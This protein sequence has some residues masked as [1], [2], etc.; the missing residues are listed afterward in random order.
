MFNDE[1]E[2]V[3]VNQY[4]ELQMYFGYDYYVT[5]K[6]KISQPTLGDIID[7]GD[8]KFYTMVSTLCANP[9]SFR[10]Q[11]WKKGIDWN[12]LSDWDLFLQIYKS[13]TPQDTSLILGE[14][15]LSWFEPHIKKEEQNVINEDKE[16]KPTIFLVYIDDKWRDENGLILQ[17]KMKYFDFNNAIIIDEFVYTQMIE[18]IRD[19]F[20]IHPKVEKAKGR[21]TKEAI[22]EEDEMNLA[23]EKKKNAKRKHNKSFLLPL[24]S[25]MVNH[26]GFKYKKNEL[27]EVG[28]VEFMDSVK[29]LQVYES[30]KAL[31]SGMYSGMCDMSKIPDLNTKLN[32]TRDIYDN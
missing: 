9:T 14:L 5:D 13:F 11:L 23:I 21:G 6:I 17:D 32:W 2:I 15:N 24:I 4:D 26:S 10:L 16:F 19:M 20:D 25:A 12:T 22:I 30:T 7:Y 28:I 18:Y 31:M 3:S 29:R 1:E 8:T 27:K